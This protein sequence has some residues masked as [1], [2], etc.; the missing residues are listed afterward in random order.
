VLSLPGRSGS[1]FDIAGLGMSGG[2][3]TLLSNP[4]TPEPPPGPGE[5]YPVPDPGEPYPAPDPR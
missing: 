2:M 5:P 3:K 1:G 4:E